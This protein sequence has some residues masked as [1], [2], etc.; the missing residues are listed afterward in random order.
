M[1]IVVFPQSPASPV[2]M[3]S[4]SQSSSL[5]MAFKTPSQPAL[6]DIWKSKII[7]LPNV[8]KLKTLQIIYYLSFIDIVID[9]ITY[10][11]LR[12]V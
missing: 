4:S 5:M 7:D 12:C 2:S 1:P 6:V 10:R 9:Q 11:G 8:S 3:L